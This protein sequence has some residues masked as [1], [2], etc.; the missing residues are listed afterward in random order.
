MEGMFPGQH[1]PAAPS[2]FPGQ[3]RPVISGKHRP[4]FPR[5]APSRSTVP[6]L[7]GQHRPAPP[8]AAPSPARQVKRS[9]GVN[10]R[11]VRLSREAVRGQCTAGEAVTGSIHGS[12]TPHLTGVSKLGGHRQ[13]HAYRWYWQTDGFG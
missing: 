8:R 9:R 3:H 5:A 11:Q 13:T 1:R 12:Q 6:P 2:P 7:P 10:A 4:A